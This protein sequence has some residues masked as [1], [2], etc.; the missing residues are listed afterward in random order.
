MTDT[1][2]KDETE[3]IVHGIMADR[4]KTI[5]EKEALIKRVMNAER[6]Q[7]GKIK[8]EVLSELLALDIKQRAEMAAAAAGA[9]VG[10]SDGPAPVRA[11]DPEDSEDS[12]SSD[13]L[14]SSAEEGSDIAELAT[15]LALAVAPVST[16]ADGAAGA[17]PQAHHHHQQQQAILFAAA[18]EL[19]KKR[20]T[21]KKMREK[22]KKMRRMK[23][24]LK[25]QKKQTQAAASATPGPSARKPTTVLEAVR[26][27]HEKKPSQVLKRYC[28]DNCLGPCKSVSFDCL[29]SWMCFPLRCLSQ[30]I[31]IACVSVTVLASWAIFVGILVFITNYAGKFMGYRMLF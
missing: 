22:A 7:R 28:N 18:E 17:T 27:A 2:A 24:Q 31:T 4:S 30:G 20:A 19:R 15:K 23:R 6:A 21:A 5:P 16:V 25:A 10:L 3:Q 26:A 11:Q 29:L 8:D 9:G 13:D 1:S 14:S 12:E